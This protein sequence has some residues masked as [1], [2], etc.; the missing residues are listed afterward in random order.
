MGGIKT[1]STPAIEEERRHIPCT[2][3]GGTVFR[4][5]LDC[6]GFSYVRCTRCSLVQMN[7]Q[8][9]AEHIARRYQNQNRENYL[10]YELANEEAFLNLQL[11][12][13]DDIAFEEIE[14]DILRGRPIP[15]DS[16]SPQGDARLAPSSGL[17]NS[18]RFLDVGCATGSLIHAMSKRGWNT[19]GVEISRDMA[20]WAVEHRGLDVR[21]QRLE[22]CAFAESSFKVVHASHLVEHL[23]NPAT[24]VDEVARILAEGGWFIVTT[25]AIDGW[26]ARLTGARWRSAIFDHLYLFSRKTLRK[27]LEDRG[28][29]IERQSS[30]GG[31]AAGMAP[32]WIKKPVD[33]LAKRCNGGDVILYAA[34]KHGY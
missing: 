27:L 6:E 11:L 1:W 12:A 5:A 33:K 34:R 32:A 14:A 21:P 29:V 20:S 19:V 10:D 23:N 4:P 28:F 22:E 13:L 2:L 9:T 31:L 26:Q 16:K 25:P 7:P 18:A 24:F 15:P 8:P 30:W 17:A 3:C